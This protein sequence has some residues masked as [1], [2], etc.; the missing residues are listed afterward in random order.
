MHNG[1]LVLSLIHGLITGALLLWCTW[2]TQRLRQQTRH[3][4]VLEAQTY[5]AWAMLGLGPTPFSHAG[6]DGVPVRVV[7]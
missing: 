1:A 6:P 3:G 4:Q 2:L 5:A 7:D